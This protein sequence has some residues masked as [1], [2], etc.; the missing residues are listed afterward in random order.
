MRLINYKKSGARFVN[1]LSIEPLL[2]AHGT[3]THFRGVLKE[4]NDPNLL[5]TSVSQ[6]QTTTTT[7]AAAAAVQGLGSVSSRALAHTLGQQGVST[8]TQPPPA[9][10]SPAVRGGTAAA[11][12]A[13]AAAAAA[14]GVT[15]QGVHAAPMSGLQ[16]WPAC[17]TTAG[18]SSCAQSTRPGCSSVVS[19]A[20]AFP[21]RGA[22][23]AAGASS[24]AGACSCACAG[25][26]SSSSALPTKEGGGGGGR[27]G[28]GGGGGVN[29]KLLSRD[30]FP[31]HTLNNHPVAPVLLRMLQLNSCTSGAA[32]DGSVASGIS[33]GGGVGQLSSR[34][35]LA[36]LQG[37]TAGGSSALLGGF[38][39]GGASSSFSQH[40]TGAVSGAAG[41]VGSTHPYSTQVGSSLYGL[42]TH[43]TIGLPQPHAYPI[44]AMSGHHPSLP[45]PLGGP[46]IPVNTN[47]GG[48]VTNPGQGFPGQ[49]QVPAQR[50]TQAFSMAS[51][52]ALQPG[53]PGGP[54][55]GAAGGQPQAP[56]PITMPNA[57]ASTSATSQH[58]SPQTASGAPGSGGD[59]S[60]G[61]EGGQTGTE[62]LAAVA[63]QGVIT[64]CSNPTGYY[65]V[66]PGGGDGSAAEAAAAGSSSGSS[67][68]GGG[69]VMGASAGRKRPCACGQSTCPA[70]SGGPSSC[71]ACSG[72]PSSTQ[73]QQ[74]ASKSDQKGASCSSGGGGGGKGAATTLPPPPGG[75]S[76]PRRAT[77]D[78]GG[79]GGGGSGGPGGDLVASLSNT[80][81]QQLAAAFS[82]SANR[83]D[84]GSGS[85]DGEA[86]GAGEIGGAGGIGEG[87]PTDPSRLSPPEPSWARAFSCFGMPT[88]GSGGTPGSGGHGGG[89]CGSGK[90]SSPPGGSIAQAMALSGASLASLVQGGSGGS[91]AGAEDMGMNLGDASE[92]QL[93]GILDMLD[94]WDQFEKPP[95]SN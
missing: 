33:P 51:A 60:G 12:A 90:R 92:M 40:G 39:G 41:A 83:G 10:P 78:A 14:A 16:E 47:T 25:P 7:A 21:I 18:C 48:P 94:N 69:A 1:E 30:A 42:G 52:Q 62:F 65:G 57:G 20:D 81:L 77:T 29:E 67:G 86:S 46:P 87:H 64:S 75:F 89:S 9:V 49:G 74:P 56:Q 68:G 35:T 8:I 55:Q 43:S 93:D 4:I 27:D 84:S 26:Q 63:G 44:S 2:D 15:T 37:A 36:M 11:T 3:V 53:P 5:S 45:A 28:A 61:R 73:G 79:G 54:A 70:C 91:A 66:G 17:T 58:P 88:S 32:A 80:S 85:G 24:S 59:G 19:V 23:G 95:G 31:L 82:R 22:M 72:G 76:W 71:P 38:G 13:A 34:E 50:T 6:S